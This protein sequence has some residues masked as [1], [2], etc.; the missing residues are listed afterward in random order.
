[1]RNKLFL[2]VC[3]LV[4]LFSFKVSYAMDD[5]IALKDFAYQESEQVEK[6]TV[7]FSNVVGEAVVRELKSPKRLVVDFEQCELRL[8]NRELE[9]NSEQIEKI[10]VGQFMSTTSRIVLDLKQDVKYDIVRDEEKYIINILKQGVTEEEYRIANKEKELEI[11]EDDEINDDV[12]N[13]SEKNELDEKSNDEIITIKDK[14]S[15]SYKKQVEDECVKIT[16]VNYNGYNVFRIKNPDRIVI[17][18]PNAYCENGKNIYRINGTYIMSIR[19][20]N[21]TETSARVILDVSKNPDYEVIEEE[22]GLKILVRKNASYSTEEGKLNYIVS[23]DRVWL[24]INKTG[25]TDRRGNNISGYT[26]R[27]NSAKKIYTILFDKD[28]ANLKDQILEINDEYIKRI[29]V[30]NN[31]D[32]QKTK[33]VFWAKDD[34]AYNIMTREKANDTAITILKKKPKDEPLVVIDAG[35][36]GKEEPGSICNLFYE[37]SV[38]LDIALRV[39]E[40]LKDKKIKTYM[41]RQS[42]TYVAEYERANIANKMD[43]SLFVSIHNNSFR[44]DANG[45]ETLYNPQNKDLNVST[46]SQYFA[47]IMQNKL[48][49]AIGTRNRGIKQRPNLIVLKQTTM[50]SVLTEVAFLTNE[51]EL[52][53][54][55]SSEFR[56]KA[57]QAIADSIEEMIKNL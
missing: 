55:N 24:K 18:I 47:N 22:D 5:L 31:E 45:T 12:E 42:D 57:A 41:T 37:K 11:Q 19:D 54:L 8:Q 51:K 40:C 25:F 7:S 39:E 1:M 33:I 27:Y 4:M 2:L 14:I 13:K 38:N 26:E 10:R 56:Q 44:G 36:G 34:F 20:S 29:E 48:I 43:A 16:V 28:I 21:F 53:M 46:K 3:S 49:D 9:V 35:H 52:E 30:V 23:G 17:D 32:T 15:I 50:P 6:I